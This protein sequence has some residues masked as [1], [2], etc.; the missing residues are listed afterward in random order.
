[1]QQAVD[2]YVVRVNQKEKN[3]P[4]KLVDVVDEVG[5]KGKRAFTNVGLPEWTFKIGG[6]IWV[7]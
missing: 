5:V 7:P 3:N 4:R 1:M 2:S 6:H